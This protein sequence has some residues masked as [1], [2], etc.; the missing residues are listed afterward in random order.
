MSLTDLLKRIVELTGGD[1][2]ES[3]I[4]LVL[5]NAKVGAQIARSLC[6]K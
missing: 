6:K 4:E 2:L 3:N 5:N 1:S